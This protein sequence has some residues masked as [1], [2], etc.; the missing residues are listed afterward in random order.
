MFNET[1][2]IILRAILIEI[3][4]Q[5]IGRVVRS[6]TCEIHQSSQAL[7]HPTINVIRASCGYLT[8]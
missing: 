7:G 5:Q 3:Y 2:T 4:E 8:P 1:K 6:L